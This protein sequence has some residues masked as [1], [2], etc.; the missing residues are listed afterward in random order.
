MLRLLGSMN[1]IFLERSHEYYTNKLNWL[2]NIYDY[3]FSLQNFIFFWI[4]SV[5]FTVYN[6]YHPYMWNIIML[7]YTLST[8]DILEF[9]FNHTSHN[10]FVMCHR[11]QWIFSMCFLSSKQ[12]MLYYKITQFNEENV[13]KL[14][15][16]YACANNERRFYWIIYMNDEVI[17]EKEQNLR[18]KGKKLKLGC[19]DLK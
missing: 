10:Q 13:I 3:S 16:I 6:R 2:R 4:G 9:F 5:Y 12:I 19:W 11:F 15:T 8:Y 1:I 18:K 17:N 7:I 14:T